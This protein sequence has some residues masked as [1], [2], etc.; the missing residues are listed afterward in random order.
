MLPPVVV[1][2]PT[3]PIAGRRIGGNPGRSPSGHSLPAVRPQ[4]EVLHR[5]PE[6]TF[7]NVLEE[8]PV[9]VSA[10]RKVASWRA[11]LGGGRYD[12]LVGDVGGERVPGVGFA[13]GD[14]VIG[15]V[16]QKYA[17]VPDVQLSPATVLRMATVNGAHALGLDATFGAIAPGKSARLVHVPVPP[18]EDPLEVV[19]RGP[20]TVEWLA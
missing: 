3:H 16:A 17:K 13:M 18:G 1:V 5:I 8:T 2:E 12:N 15:L 7:R 9:F 14:A 11:I 6:V 19:T 20:E 4:A 10:I